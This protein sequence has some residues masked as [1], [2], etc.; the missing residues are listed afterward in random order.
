MSRVAV[1]ATEKRAVGRQRDDDDGP[2]GRPELFHHQRCLGR[3]PQSVR[4]SVRQGRCPARDP[5]ER[6][7]DLRSGQLQAGRSPELEARQV[8]RGQGHGDGDPPVGERAAHDRDQDGRSR[9]LMRRALG[10]GAGRVAAAL[11]A[12]GP[13][14]PP[15]SGFTLLFLRRSPAASLGGLSWA[16]RSEE[17]T[18]ELQSRPHLVCRLLLEKKKNIPAVVRFSTYVLSAWMKLK[19][20]FPLTASPTPPISGGNLV[21]MSFFPQFVLRSMTPLNSRL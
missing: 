6:R 8:H 16:P 3:R 9:E 19:A 14:A 17:H 2:G 21:N 20:S 11:L 1:R 13:P 12:C 15:P 18:S 7:H 5:G 4:A 10:G